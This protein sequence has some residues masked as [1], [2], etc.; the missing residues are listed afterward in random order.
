MRTPPITRETLACVPE[1]VAGFFAAAL[2]DPVWR[3]RLKPAQGEQASPQITGL[4]FGREIF[5]N[6]VDFVAYL[7]PPATDGMGSTG[8]APDVAAVMRVNDPSKSEMLWTQILGIGC[9][10]AGAPTTDGKVEPMHGAEVRT[11]KFPAGVNIMFA[12]IGDKI[13]IATT[14]HAMTRALEATQGGASVLNDEAFA[15]SLARVNENTSKAVFAHPGRCFAVAQKYMSPNDIKEAE[16]FVAMMSHLVASMLTDESETE[17]RLSVEATGLPNVGELAAQLLQRE[18]RRQHT[19]RKLT[20]AMDS[21]NWEQALDVLKEVEAGEPNNA[22]HIRSRF[23]ILA[24]GKNDPDAAIACGREYMKAVGGNA[25][26]LNNFAW[27][28]LTTDQYG[29]PYHQLA[30]EVAT[31]ACELSKYQVAAFVD[32]L[33]LAEFE[34]GNTSRAL[35][36]QRKAV[37]LPGGDG[38]DYRKALARYEAALSV[39]SEVRSE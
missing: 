5:A 11:Y 6:I 30:L 31:K 20:K 19:Q 28:L 22:K 27:N 8:P 7:M 1:G 14:R 25:T 35:E 36:L 3:A 37:E 24:T 18:E 39:S 2:G 38:P 33:A 15:P 21:R 12:A 32:T 13:V 16:P 17:F 23:K 34:N 29:D 4:D 9:L 26:V 10:A